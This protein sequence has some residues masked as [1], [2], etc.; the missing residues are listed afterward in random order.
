M[1]RLKITCWMNWGWI[2][3]DPKTQTPVDQTSLSALITKLSTSTIF[4]GEPPKKYMMKQLCHKLWRSLWFWDSWK[5]VHHDAFKESVACVTLSRTG[6]ATDISPTFCSDCR[7]AM[8]IYALVTEV[9]PADLWGG[10]SRSSDTAPVSARMVYLYTRCVWGVVKAGAGNSIRLSMAHMSGVLLL[11]S[12]TP[13]HGRG[14][15]IS[16]C[17]STDV[18]SAI[19]KRPFWVCL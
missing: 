3:L 7:T 13:R 16:M 18:A 1:E 5:G 10:T 17:G 12:F 8:L 11:C 19:Y 4:Q 15:H 9:Y 2:F 14:D 6:Q